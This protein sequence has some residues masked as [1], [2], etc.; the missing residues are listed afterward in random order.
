M[1]EGAVEN[2]SKRVTKVLVA[3]IVVLAL[4]VIYS[5][6][7]KPA[8]SGYIVSAQ[9][10]LVSAQNTGA[11]SLMG[12][13]ISELNQ[14]GGYVQI[15]IGNQTLVLMTPQYCQSAMANNGASKA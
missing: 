5:F 9:N 2:N 3:V 1:K 11:T 14:T 6:V 10:K 4:L 12:S 15:P 7:V 13:I 8:V